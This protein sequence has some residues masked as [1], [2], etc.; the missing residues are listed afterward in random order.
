MAN[1]F[2]RQS[3]AYDYTITGLNAY[4]I[5]ILEMSNQ[6]WPGGLRWLH[7]EDAE[8]ATPCAPADA[9]GPRG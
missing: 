3:E 1:Y 2:C 8:A 6:G 4:C 5:S 7:G 9:D